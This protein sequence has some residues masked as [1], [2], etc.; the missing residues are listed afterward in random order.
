MILIRRLGLVALL[1]VVAPAFVD[2]EVI[3]YY[4]L[5]GNTTNQGTGGGVTS[6]GAGLTYDADPFRGQVGNFASSTAEFDTNV[7]AD[8]V[9]GWVDGSLLFRKPGLNV[10]LAPAAT[11][12]SSAKLPTVVCMTVFEAVAST[13]VAGATTAA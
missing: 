1:A 4:D 11:A 13:W 5:D 3:L 10:P 2:A 6:G 8:F 7:P 12:L 9:S